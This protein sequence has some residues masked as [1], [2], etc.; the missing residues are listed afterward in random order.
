[1][2]KAEA[3]VARELDL[4]VKG[5]DILSWERQK[6]IELFGEN[7]THICNYFIDFIVHHLDGRDEYL[8]VKGFETTAWR[9]KK[10]LMEDKI[11]GMK[12]AYYTVRKV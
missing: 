5:H 12:N 6:K 1:M 8:E 3:E 10:K 7:K 11:K 4:R 2:S 9:M